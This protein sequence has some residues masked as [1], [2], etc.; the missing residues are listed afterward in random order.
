MRRKLSI[1]SK[2]KTLGKVIRDCPRLLRTGMKGGGGG[3]WLALLKYKKEFNGRVRKD[4]EALHSY[5]SA[6]RLAYDRAY[7]PPPVDP[8]PTEATAEQKNKHL[9]Q[10]GALKFCNLQRDEDILCQ[11]INGLNPVLREVLI[12]QDDLLQTPVETVVRRIANLEQEK[13]AINQPEQ[14]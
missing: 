10:T 1:T 12:R 9:E 14:L 4:G 2:K 7:R 5:L 11:F 6:L 8:L 13:G 3:G